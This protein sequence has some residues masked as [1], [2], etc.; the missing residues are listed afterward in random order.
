MFGAPLCTS[1]VVSFG[2]LSA[3]STEVEQE[4][5]EPCVSP[6]CSSALR[7][8][9]ECHS[10]LLGGLHCDLHCSATFLAQRRLPVS[11]FVPADEHCGNECHS[12]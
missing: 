2:E 11:G 5:A 3:K 7:S 12:S 10:A 1:G 4:D 8:A 9:L 6:G